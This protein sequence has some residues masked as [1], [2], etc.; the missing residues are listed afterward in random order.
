MKENKWL[1]YSMAIMAMTFWGVSYVWTKIVFDYY[2]PL[3]IM[4]IRL[5]ISSLLIYAFIRFR[6]QT[7]RIDRNDYKSFFILSFFSPFCYFLGENFGL[8]HVTPTVA[9]IVIATIPVFAPILGFLAFR[10]R[11]SAINIMGFV[12]GFGGI[13]IM[14]LDHE[15]KFNASPLGVS[16]LL[17]AVASALVNMVYLKRLAIKY[18]PLHIIFV[19]NV[20]GAALFMPVFLIF[21]L[22]TFVTIRPSTEA[23]LSLL[24]LAVF[25]S[26][27]A[28]IFYTASVRS[29]GIA[30]TSIFGN[31]IPVFAALTSLIVLKE[32][33]DAGKIAGM[34]LVIGGLLLT[35]LS[36]IHKK[37]K[38]RRGHESPKK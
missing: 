15:F 27:L 37:R 23:I 21:D 5:C 17:F 18:S 30:R 38:L 12:I 8:L 9:A 33:I 14:V 11:I 35:Q 3:T 31:L 2:Q 7:F 25:G 10:E 4:F 19:Q 1:I 29:L 26:T 32:V 34:T 22:K 6:Q 28:F 16:L 13:W 24:A 36:A 20:L